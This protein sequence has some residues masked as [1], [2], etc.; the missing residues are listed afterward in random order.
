V[1]RDNSRLIVFANDMHQKKKHPLE[2]NAIKFENTPLDKIRESIYQPVHALPLLVFLISQSQSAKLVMHFHL[3]LS[4][5]CSSA[6]VRMEVRLY[7][8]P[9]HTRHHW[10]NK[11]AGHQ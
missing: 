7:G 9:K 10:G 5:S 8:Y 4:V 6:C 2:S 3:K 11:G 1:S